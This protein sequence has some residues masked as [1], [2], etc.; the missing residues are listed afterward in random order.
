MQIK[1]YLLAEV[2]LEVAR[3]TPDHDKYQSTM[4]RAEW[5][6]SIVDKAMEIISECGVD[7]DSEDLDEIVENYF[8]RRGVLVNNG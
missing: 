1:P 2:A 8:V 7:G 6:W 4:P 3:F 5:R